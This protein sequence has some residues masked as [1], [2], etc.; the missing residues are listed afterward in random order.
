MCVSLTQTRRPSE[1]DHSSIGFVDV[2]V[3]NA[4]PNDKSDMV[5]H[6]I[7]RLRVGSCE[8]VDRLS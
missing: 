7:F 6:F 4:K 2:V 3:A 1:I 8:F 5:Q